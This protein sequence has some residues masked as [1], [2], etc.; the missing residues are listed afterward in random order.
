MRALA[1]LLLLGAC[2]HQLYW[3]KDGTSGQATAADLY[4]CR[5]KTAASV[6]G[7]AVYTAAELERPCMAAKGYH[8]SKTPAQ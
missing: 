2:S 3:V 5:T 8:L 4:E 1:L 7:Q 6:P